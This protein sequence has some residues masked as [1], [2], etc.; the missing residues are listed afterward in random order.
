MKKK[1]LFTLLIVLACVIALTVSVSAKTVISE[2]NLDANGDGELAISF[3][4]DKD[5]LNEYEHYNSESLKY[6][7]FAI[8]YKNITD[9]EIIDTDSAVIAEVERSYAS[10]EMKITG[11]ETEAQRAAEISFGAYVID[12]NG[13][14]TY[15][16][17]NLPVEGDKYAYITYKTV[18]NA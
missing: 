15:I 3:A 12:K 9:D 18:A 7:A 4:V 8:A 5:A 2:N 14:A 6:G 11:I 10:F 1:I 16:Q 17:P 13:K